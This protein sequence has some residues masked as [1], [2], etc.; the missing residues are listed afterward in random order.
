MTARPPWGFKVLFAVMK[1]ITVKESPLLH[2]AGKSY[3]LFKK[4]K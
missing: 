1:L 3:L 4:K 2:T